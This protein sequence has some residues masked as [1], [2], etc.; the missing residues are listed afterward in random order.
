MGGGGAILS[1]G[2]VATS[3]STFSGNRALV[4]AERAL[5]DCLESTELVLLLGTGGAISSLGYV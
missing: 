3:R 4:P 1:I 2:Q 5:D